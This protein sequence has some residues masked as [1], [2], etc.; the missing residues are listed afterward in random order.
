MS[1]NMKRLRRGI[2]PALV[3]LPL[4]LHGGQNGGLDYEFTK[5]GESYSFRGRFRVKAELRCLMDVIYRFEHISRFASGAE[6]VELVEEGEDWHVVAYTYRRLLILENQSTWRRVLDRQGQRVVFEM[7]TSE[8][9]MRIMPRV[10]SSR[11]YYQIH[12]DGKRYCLEYFQECHLEGGVLR[13]RY[14]ERAKREAE[15]FLGEFRGYVESTCGE[16]DS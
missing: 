12:G 14:M 9:S 11:G 10:L 7:L 6:S 16:A 2:L 4:A 1:I 5:D 3:V 15:E 13:G 8:N